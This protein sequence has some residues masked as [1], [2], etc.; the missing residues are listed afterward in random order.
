MTPIDPSLPAAAPPARLPR[1]VVALGWVS[2]LT[3]AASDMI[4]PLL[5]AFLLAL[6]GSAIDIGWLEGIAEAVGAALKLGSGVVSDRVARRKP[7]IAIGYGLS[8]LTRPLFAIAAAPLFAVLVRALDR[9]GKGLRGPP[10][11]A[12]VADAAPPAMRGHAFGFHRM[13]DNSG[14][15][16]GALLAYI[17]LRYFALDLRT[18]FK[19]AIIPAWPRCSSSSSSCASRRAAC[20]PGSR[21]SR[22]R[23]S[24]AARRSRRR[25]A[26]ISGR[27]PC[28]RWRARATSSSSTGS[29]IWVCQ[30]IW[31]PSC[32]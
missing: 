9:V 21:A 24:P 18:V 12:M 10:R 5:P 20:R 17:F 7:L 30:R 22:G 27:S 14:A 13:M 29:S 23:R 26:A 25:R 19:L 28:S 6:G 15:V 8:A 32:G 2:L 31:C 3:D 11:D 4:Y 1:T 16:V